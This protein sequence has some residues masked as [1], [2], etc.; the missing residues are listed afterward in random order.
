MKSIKRLD[1][2]QTLFVKV[3]QQGHI[4]RQKAAV[5]HSNDRYYVKVDGVYKQIDEPREIL[6]TTDIVYII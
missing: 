5:Y 3:I 1:G 6:D 4:I 2:Q